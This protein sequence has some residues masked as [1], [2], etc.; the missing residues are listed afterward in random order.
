MVDD[1]NH[2]QFDESSWPWVRNI[3]YPQPNFSECAAVIPEE[4][5]IYIV[6]YNLCVCVCV[7]V[8][9][10]EF[11]C[12]LSRDSTVAIPAFLNST[13]QIKSVC[14]AVGNFST[15]KSCIRKLP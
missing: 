3:S 7:C 9:L 4:V 11:V 2:P 14:L 15:C 6:T 8:T 1:T 13:V 12:L 10:A 5:S